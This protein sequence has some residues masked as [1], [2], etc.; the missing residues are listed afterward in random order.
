ML[1]NGFLAANS[2]SSQRNHDPGQHLAPPHPMAPALGGPAGYHTPHRPIMDGSFESSVVVGGGG[3]GVSSNGGG[4]GGGGGGHCA[5]PN[6]PDLMTNIMALNN[7][8]CPQCQR[9]PSFNSLARLVQEACGHFKCRQCLL[10]EESGCVQCKKQDYIRAQSRARSHGSPMAI[11]T[12]SLMPN[13]QTPHN[14]F[15]SPRPLS[16]SNQSFTYPHRQ[17]MQL[18]QLQLRHQQHQQQQQ[19]Q[20]HHEQQQQHQHLQHQQ[21]FQH[22]PHQHQQQQ[23]QQMQRQQQ[24]EHPPPQVLPHRFPG[25]DANPLAR[26]HAM[27]PPFPRGQSHHALYPEV[28]IEREEAALPLSTTSTTHPGH[29]LKNIH[30]PFG[31]HATRIHGSGFDEPA[32]P[33]SNHRHELEPLIR[34]CDDPNHS[35]N[36]SSSNQLYSRAP[37]PIIEGIEME[38]EDADSATSIMT[39]TSLQDLAD[40]RLTIIRVG[41][42]VRLS[43]FESLDSEL[44]WL[45]Q[46]YRSRIHDTLYNEEDNCLVVER[47]K[48]VSQGFLDKV[49]GASELSNEEEQT[50]ELELNLEVSSLA[51]EIHEKV[52][53]RARELPSEDLVNFGV[54]DEGLVLRGNASILGEDEI[55]QEVD[56]PEEHAFPQSMIVTNE[57]VRK[58]GKRKRNSIDHENYAH[59]VKKNH[60]DPPEYLCS[61]CNRQFKNRLN[62]R[63]H[64]ACADKS[65]GHACKE[66]DRI[67]KSSSHLTYHMRT[68]HGG[69]KPYKCRFCEK[70]FAQSVKLK[71]HERTH[72]GER[73]FKC[74]ICQHTFTTKYNL[75]EHENIHKSEKPYTCSVCKA[76]F[77]DRNNLRRHESTHDSHGQ[78]KHHSSKASNAALCKA[79]ASKALMDKMTSEHEKLITVHHNDIKQ[80]LIQQTSRIMAQNFSLMKESLHAE[81]LS[82]NRC[83]PASNPEDGSH[84]TNEGENN[85]HVKEDISSEAKVSLPGTPSHTATSGMETFEKSPNTNENYY[86][87]SPAKSSAHPGLSPEPFVDEGQ[88][89]AANLRTDQADMSNFSSSSLNTSQSDYMLDSPPIYPSYTSSVNPAEHVRVSA[90]VEIKD[91]LRRVKGDEIYRVVDTLTSKERRAL[92]AILKEDKNAKT[93]RPRPHFVSKAVNF[94]AF[95]DISTGSK[96]DFLRRYQRQVLGECG[97]STASSASFP[98]P[99]AANSISALERQTIMTDIMLDVEEA[100]QGQNQATHYPE[101]VYPSP[102]LGP[103]HR[104]VGLNSFDN[105]M[106][107]IHEVIAKQVEDDGEP[108]SQANDH[109]KRS[110]VSVRTEQGYLSKKPF[111]VDE[112]EEESCRI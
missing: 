63:Y 91:L 112:D 75:K 45:Q 40:F 72:T 29:S 25:P 43:Q 58:R 94:D 79:R 67:F 103:N 22:Q 12:P 104:A 65:A 74:E 5:T 6:S 99:T 10:R 77:A 35:N 20:Q 92:I 4:G 31:E 109:Q 61:I 80:H 98:F 39:P 66:C 13:S 7:L 107:G 34:M 84:K 16:V 69:E 87:A 2:R 59:I 102:K 68:A 48:E 19:Q 18:H 81:S 106:K 32:S 89:E 3:G 95:S 82:Q 96:K 73:P 56:G 71:R 78:G 60:L 38:R 76:G 83:Q 27:V 110:R 97:S 57:P 41:Q 101:H 88:L 42:W 111:L 52:M 46:Q 36:S 30:P 70:A 105:I 100:S 9:V 15:V 44:D 50:D 64:I 53:Q 85:N 33:M 86:V 8:P 55:K 62:I 17:H 37:S 1:H 11:K 108:P 23:Q 54:Q 51:R 49:G 24:P 90:C 26:V 14:N 28:K 47:G 21:Q 93:G